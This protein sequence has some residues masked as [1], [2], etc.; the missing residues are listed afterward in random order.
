[1]YLSVA[2]AAIASTLV[3]VAATAQVHAAADIVVTTTADVVDEADG[4]LSL[5]EAVSQA[6]SQAGDDVIV[7][8]SGIYALTIV[9][10]PLVNNNN[11]GGDLDHLDAGTT[12]T[13]RGAG[14]SSTSIV[15]VAGD[16]VM[17]IHSGS[18]LVLED[19]TVTGG[20]ETGGAG[21]Q[22]R[23]GS[24][25]TDRVVISGNDASDNGGGIYLD[26]P[27]GFTGTDTVFLGNTAT[28]SGGGLYIE[29]GS[30]TATDVS[31]T[32]NSATVDAGA[33]IRASGGPFSFTG[34]TWS[35]N[36]AQRIG[37]VARLVG[38][39]TVTITDVV[40]TN[41]AAT[42]EDGGVLSTDGGSVTVSGS[43]FSDNTAKRDGGAIY[44]NGGSLSIDSSTFDGNEATD[45]SGGAIWLNDGTTLTVATSTFS[46]NSAGGSGGA[47]RQLGD[48]ASINSSLFDGN[49]ATS[50]GGAL[51]TATDASV[52]VTNSTLVF[53]TAGTSGG[54]MK[55]GAVELI[56]ST[57]TSNTASSFGSNIRAESLS[58]KST[59]I[60]YGKV[61]AECQV[62]GVTTSVSSFGGDT[63]CFGAAMGDPKLG[64]LAN[65]GGPTKTRQPAFDSPLVGAANAVAGVTTDQRGVARP[66][67]AAADIGAVE[68]R[69][70][71][72]VD[73]AESTDEDTAVIVS[74]LD[75]DV[76]LDSVIAAETVVT[77]SGPTFGSTKD[78]GDGTI[79]YTPSPGYFGE[80]TFTYGFNSGTPLAD[81][82]KVT[83]TVQSVGSRFIDTDGS[84][85]VTEIEW[86]AAEGITKGCNPPTNSMFCPK[87][88]VTR[89]QMAAFLNRAFNLP[90]TSEDFF[91]D[92]DDSVFEGDI[93]RLAAAGITK[94]CNPPKND[95][96][97]VDGKVI[98]GQMAA[99]LVR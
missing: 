20:S 84:V 75:N 14:S 16:R 13:I 22:V 40:S 78:N 93:N 53:N 44:V 77:T 89:G 54:A 51:S 5:R 3:L 28:N 76:D 18:S 1:M 82:A 72:A 97:C 39:P 71:M 87:G 98:R 8:S 64:A 17:D 55:S 29:D 99:F 26:S 60:A 41:N 46:N 32:N 35:G 45:S 33:G 67:G 81:G 94:G 12:L 68:V 48:T 61:V 4:V 83:I 69:S 30:V 86:L 25:T 66:D 62:T 2:L 59:V 31:F 92:D 91:T 21:I 57:V 37:G 10:P 49:T 38:A 24:V 58:A 27:G 63:S 96:F 56:F 9:S 80:D 52:T 70:P 95:L 36:T 43:S 88:N 19:L 11:A 15:A 23:G 90:A 34:G 73:D 47:I 74:V 7:L 42:T 50:F 85:F 79:T 6:N 65:N